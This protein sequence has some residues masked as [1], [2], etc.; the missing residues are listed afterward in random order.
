[1]KVIVAGAGVGSYN[2]FTNE[3]IEA[4]KSGDEVLTSGRL[5]EELKKLNKN[6]V[7]MSVMEIVRYINENAKAN[8]TLIVAATGDTGFYSISGTIAK[9][10]DNEIQ[11]EYISGIGSLAYF[12]S[13]IKK[14]YENMKLI[15]L[16]GRKKNIIPFVSYNRCVFTL[17]GGEVKAHNIIETLVDNNLGDVQIYVGENLSLE[18]ERIL[19]GKARELKNIEFSD[20]AVMVIENPDFTNPYITL[21]DEDFTRGKSPM[22]KE[23]I[24]TLAVAA[25]EIEPGDVCYDIGSGTGSVTCQMALKAREEMVYAIEKNSEAVELLAE[26]MKKLGINNI[27]YREG[28]A[29]EG[30]DEFPPADKVFIGGSS[31]NLKEIVNCILERNEKALFVVTTITLETLTEAVELF[32]SDDFD[33]SVSCVNVSNAKKL[34]DYNLMMAENPVYII[35]G[36][37][38]IE[39]QNK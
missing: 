18:D 10:V 28:L 9:M 23:G 35:K 8:K 24:R 14:G 37:K 16:H 11:V 1:M 22:T 30:L 19:S 32:N 27:V 34:G 38:K 25:L 21:K 26:N 3:F 31:K 17:T 36:A 7:S 4:V 2:N 39:Q 5:T 33:V 6:T 13:K 15:S 29:P 20:L 12:C